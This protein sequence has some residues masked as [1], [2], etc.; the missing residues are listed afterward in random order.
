MRK[1]CIMSNSFLH[2][3]GGKYYTIQKFIDESN[4]YGVTRRVSLADLKR[5]N[6]S[7][8]VYC[9][10]KKKNANYGSVFGRFMITGISGLNQ[11]AITAISQSHRIEAMGGGGRMVIRGCGMYIEGESY[12]VDATLPELAETL[13]NAKYN[14]STSPQNDSS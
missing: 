11:T 2:W 8:W 6:F 12:Q 3:I 5:M 14:A 9:V 7:D 10:Q 4:E 1:E 13:S